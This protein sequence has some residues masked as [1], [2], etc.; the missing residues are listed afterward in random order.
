MNYPENEKHET[1]QS[2]PYL[3][4][5]SPLQ[6]LAA[7]LCNLSSILV[8]TSKFA[9]VIIL[10][11]V[12]TVC[13]QSYDSVMSFLKALPTETWQSGSWEGCAD[14]QLHDCNMTEIWHQYKSRCCVIEYQVQTH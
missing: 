9:F 2:I 3:K 4:L 14:T 13:L 1:R 8:R 5:G 12:V 7:T 11:I 6:F 10:T